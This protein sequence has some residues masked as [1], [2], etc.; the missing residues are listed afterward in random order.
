MNKVKIEKFKKSCGA[1]IIDSDSEIIEVIDLSFL[2]S[3]KKERKLVISEGV[4]VNYYFFISAEFKYNFLQTIAIEVRDRAIANFY[5]CFLG[6]G[7]T[8]VDVKYDIYSDS[9]V[10]HNLVYLC[11]KKNSFVVSENFNFLGSNSNGEFSS[12]GVSLNE[13][14]VD[15]KTNIYIDRDTRGNVADLQ[16]KLHLQ[17]DRSLGNLLP[18]LEVLSPLAHTSHSAKVYN[19]KPSDMNYINSKGIK[20]MTASKVLRRGVFKIFADK[21]DDRVLREK[22]LLDIK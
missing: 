17:S 3:K 22:I 14:S 12:E 7:S 6:E 19:F 9:Y 1:V 16:M 13:G 4:K 15:Y 10:N 11:K 5:Y 2:N 18:S 8:K 20:N 21:V